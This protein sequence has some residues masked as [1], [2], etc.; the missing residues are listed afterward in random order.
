MREAHPTERAVGMVWYASDTA[1]TG[2]RLRRRPADFRVCERERFETQ[3]LDRADPGSYPH[4]VCRVTLTGW[5]TNDFARELAGRLGMSRERVSWAGTKDKYAVSTQLFS[6]RAP[7]CDPDALPEIKEATIEPVGWSGRELRFGDLAGNGF[8][9]TVSEPP[10]PERAGSITTEL[11]ATD[12]SHRKNPRHDGETG[13]SDDPTTISLP[14]YFGQ[15][16]FGSRR[17]VTHRV[18]LAILR[19]D[20]EGAVMAYLGGP[21]DNEPEAT[22]TART[23]VE[24]TRD[25]TEATER[26]PGGLRYERALCQR[27]AEIERASETTDDPFREAL[28]A[29]PRSLQRLFVNAAQSYLFN[30]IV[31]ER[32]RQGLGIDR[33]VAGDVACFTDR[34]APEGLALPD[35]SRTQR[36]TESRVE[37]IDRHCARGRAFLTAPLIGTETEFAEGDPGAI[38]RAV[39]DAEALSREDFDLPDPYYS[40]GTRRA[41]SLR[42][43]ITIETDPLSF[44]FELPKGSYATT[45]LR[46]YLKS[47]PTDLA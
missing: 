6:I 25:W 14:N 16:R 36:V 26:F 12:E 8:S 39:L 27:L 33:A 42:T 40:S 20:W 23:F 29:F 17:T 35:V 19:R 38:E 2:G 9:I 22:R 3:P 13:N 30:R 11:A 10:H 37:V 34:E 45:V 31:S 1:G 44:S 46:E 43:A 18:G 28:E 32:L 15:Q 4:L 21:T 24:R 5:D 7:D 47:D 41:I